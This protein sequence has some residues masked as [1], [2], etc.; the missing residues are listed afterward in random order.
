M[1]TSRNSRK[2]RR[3]VLEREQNP[4]DEQKL[5]RDELCTILTQVETYL[6]SR[7][8][9]TLSYDPTDLLLTSL[10]PVHFL[11]GDILPVPSEPDL[12]NMSQNKLN[13]LQLFW[14]AC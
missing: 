12:T 3:L 14:Q 10:T 4:W 6:N 11:I 2:F 7:P 5:T 9:Y 8:L 13:I 1:M